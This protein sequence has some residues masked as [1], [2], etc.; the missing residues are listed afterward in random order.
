[1]VVAR[2][3]GGRRVWSACRLLHDGGSLLEHGAAAAMSGVRGSRLKRSVL[4]CKK[5]NLKKYFY[6]MASVLVD[7]RQ[8]RNPMAPIYLEPRHKRD[9]M[10]SGNNRGQNGVPFGL[11]SICLGSRPK[12]K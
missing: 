2:I 9:S 4:C 11:T 3:C 5:F 8:K 6:H 1:M 10:A 7:T 12:T